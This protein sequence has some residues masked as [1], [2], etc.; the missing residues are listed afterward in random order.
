MFWVKNAVG[1]WS[2]PLEVVISLL[3]WGL[4]VVSWVA[5][6]GNW[7]GDGMCADA[8]GT[9]S[10]GN[11]FCRIGW[12]WIRGPVGLVPEACAASRSGRW[13]EKREY[14]GLTDGGSRF[15][16]PCCAV[17]VAGGGFV[18]PV[19][20]MDDYGGAGHGDQCGVGGRVLGLG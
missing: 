10:I 17:G 15:G 9:R 14:A 1:L 4:R 3:Y 20:A 8:G 16:V 12:S 5:G 13:E 11:S 18:V 7:G 19:A 6:W 2:A